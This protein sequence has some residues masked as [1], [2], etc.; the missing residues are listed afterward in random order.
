[1]NIFNLNYHTN[2]MFVYNF[3]VHS[4][5]NCFHDDGGRQKCYIYN[6]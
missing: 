4:F 2:D 5:S 6:Q 1:M 3:I